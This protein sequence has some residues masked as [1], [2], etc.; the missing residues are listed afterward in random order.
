M[1][2]ARLQMKMQKDGTDKWIPHQVRK[3]IKKRMLELMVLAV[4]AGSM[5]GCGVVRYLMYVVAPE[6]GS[7]LVAAE[8]E[9]LTEGKRVLVLV[10]ADESMQYRSNG[11]ARYNT[12]AAV[13]KELEERL[14]V[15][16]VDA[17]S[18]E[19]FQVNNLRWQDEHPS[20]A[21]ERFGADFVLY[22]ELHEYTTQAEESGELLRGR[23]KGTA[24]LFSVAGAEG[25]PVSQLWRGRVGAE[26][27]PDVPAV[28]DMANEQVI[29]FRTLAL[30]AEDLVKHFYNHRE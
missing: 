7:E 30:F 12:S 8:C 24:V 11:L 16:V 5:S 19:Y 6:S 15:D 4:V 10:Y 13:G 22:V 25:G 28:A 17:S 18:V 14:R 23:M 1:Q 20:T 29:R 21:G 9:S 2:K 3:D 27:P 26:Y